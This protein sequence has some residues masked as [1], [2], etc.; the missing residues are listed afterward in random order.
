MVS[1]I[2]SSGQINNITSVN[3]PQKADDNQKVKSSQTAIV[4]EIVISEDALNVS[5]AEMTA[6]QLAKQLSSD[7]GLSLSS[8]SSFKELL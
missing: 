8:S 6:K 3:K 5:Q 1:H 4:D 7:N 2:N